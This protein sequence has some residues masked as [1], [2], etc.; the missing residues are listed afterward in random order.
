MVVCLDK[1]SD[2]FVNCFFPG[3]LDQRDSVFNRKNQLN[4]QLG[5]R[6]G[7]AG[8]FHEMY[9]KARS[10]P[11]ERRQR[12][13]IAGYLQNVPNGTQGSDKHTIHQAANAVLL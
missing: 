12:I 13:L 2:I 10:V 4:M 3:R 11:M 9:E 5:V 1:R 6:V 7:H 8:S